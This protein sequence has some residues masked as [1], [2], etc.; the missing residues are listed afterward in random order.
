MEAQVVAGAVFVPVVPI[1]Y[2]N[3]AVAY[4]VADFQNV[5]FSPMPAAINRAYSL[6][7]FYE[8]LSNGLITMSGRVFEPARMDTTDVYYQDGCNGV[9][10][11][12]SCPNGGRRF[13]AMLLAALDSISLRPGG[14]TTWSRFDNDGAD[15]LP[16]SGDDDGVVDFV[17]FLHPTVDGSCSTPG[18]W[19]HRHFISAWNGGSSYV[20]KTARRDGGGAPIPNQF[21]RLENYTIQSQLGGNTGCDGLNIMPIGTIAHET[22]HAFGLPDLYD[23]D[24]APRT[25]GIGEWG[26]MGSGNFAR[27][28]SPASYDAWSLLELGWVTVREL[29]Q[30]Q[31]VTTGPR[32]VTDTVFLAHT[33]ISSQHFLIENRQAFQSDT[34]QMN[35]TYG[36][37]RKSPGLLVWLID[38]A[39][40]AQ[41]RPSN[42]INT[43]SL[44]GVALMQADGLNQLRTPGLRNRGDVGDSYPGSTGNVRFGASTTPA[45][46]T[47]IGEYAGFA[48]D[49]I[50]QLPAGVM[51]FRFTRRQPSVF[52]SARPGGT[53]TVNGKAATRVEEVYPAGDQV[54]LS[55]DTVQMTPD[56]RSALR[57][58]AWSNGG[59][60]EQ[61]LISGSKPDTLSASFAARHRVRATVQGGGLVSAS[62]TG[63]LSGTGILVEEGSTVTLT[64]LPAPGTVMLGWQGDTV[65]ATA[66]LA[67]TMTRPYD[68]T[69]VFTAEQ[70]IPIQDATD[71]LLGTPKLSLEQRDY[72]DQLGNR[73]GSYD[74]GDYLALLRRTG[75]SPSPALLAKLA[76][77]QQ[78]RR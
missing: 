75:A 65:A 9:G 57:F 50:L 74:V 45:S 70:Q 1:A 22:G 27:A 20:T 6:K 66:T 42:R 76:E 11:V 60:R 37:K 13:G 49:Q 46:R 44:Q 23:T 72:L 24:A 25:E 51:Q 35:P 34:A 26:L 30:N 67:L 63:D 39:R 8:E 31:V 5:L 59:P 16:N 21:I 19:A 69:A 41:G 61:L 4:P 36:T 29:T 15:G 55:V 52:A 14:D 64:A 77:V 43:G 71:E 48:V 10:V 33:P 62:A 32:Q 47:S 28:Y 73:N 18:I 2:S 68:V 58:I 12:N 40:I 78:G 56:G 54:A 3:V 38:V 17:T 7:T 53:V